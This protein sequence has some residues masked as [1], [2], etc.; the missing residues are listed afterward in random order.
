MKQV[1]QRLKSGKLVLL[2]LPTPA[3]EE[4]RVLVRVMSSLI[5]VGTERSTLDFA[6]M[7]LYEKAKSRP[8]LVKRVFEKALATGVSATVESIRNKFSDVI[9]P[10]YSAA[11]IVVAVGDG[12]RDM[13]PGDRVACAGY[14][15]AFHAELISVPRNLVV[16]IP[17]SV[18]F[19]A[20]AFTTL[21]AIA[22]HGVRLAGAQLGET[23]GVIGLGIIGQLAAQLLKASGCRVFGFDTDQQRCEK[24]L[25]FGCDAVAQTAEEFSHLVSSRCPIGADAV[26]ITAATASDEPVD[27]AGRIARERAQ[28]I[29]VGDVGLRVPRDVYYRKE[30]TL[31][32]SR[33]YGPGRYDSSYEE[34]GQDYPIGFVRWTENRNMQAFAEMLSDRRVDV[35]PLITHRFRLE[36]AEQAY[37]L[38]TGKSGERYI[39]VILNYPSAPGDARRIVLNETP[40]K[41]PTAG[42]LRTGLIGA[43]NFAATIM[44]PALRSLGNTELI[45]LADHDGL[46]ARKVG[47]RFGFRYATTDE[48]QILADPGIDLVAITTPH[49]LH[50]GLV[51]QCLDAGKKV[52]VEKPLCLNYAE[53]SELAAKY[54]SLC[55]GDSGAPHHPFVMVGFNRRFAPLVAILREA[56]GS[57]KD[58][59]YLSYRVNAGYVPPDHWIQ[60]PGRGGGRLLGE[61]CHFV[62]LLTYLAGGPPNDVLTEAMPDSGR[63]SQDNF[64]ITMRFP[65]G[66]IATIAYISSGDVQL[67]KE[68][69]EVFGGGLSARLDDCR[70][71][72]LHQSGRKTLRE[73]RTSDK[74]HGKEWEA[75]SESL[76][77]TGVP[78][79]SFD[80]IVL[81]TY[82]TLAAFE[83]LK[84]GERVRVAPL[85]RNA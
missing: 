57:V 8:D 11:G 40:G 21:G 25:G 45:G 81:S 62:D 78:P 55:R 18:E 24:G 67:G 31:R 33:S 17:A 80:D 15:Y 19:D 43:G 49:N 46:K 7:N 41:L 4:G 6:R 1:A 54:D 84:S 37:D 79:I 65:S 85:E 12:V 59:L 77:R 52:F 29:V 39:G 76:T 32:V 71:L 3:A 44:L 16:Q 82:V 66:S 22:L 20:A 74:G 26:V 2:E 72:E 64:L 34:N 13:R 61:A 51:L 30:I 9:T 10:G 73:S 23:V 38:I 47:D 75:I 63:Y 56:L 70:R 60:D 42:T 50:A 27:L 48:R 28:V 5:S 14:G 68:S 36:E 53:L 58:P 35:S 83:S 69:L